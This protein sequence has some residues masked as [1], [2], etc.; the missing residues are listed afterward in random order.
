MKIKTK[1]LARNRW[2]GIL[3]ELGIDA[4]HLVNQ[5]GPC[6]LCGGSDRFRFDDKGGNGTYFCSGCGSGDG[7]KLAMLWTGQAFAACAAR[8]DEMC[9]HIEAQAPQT[10]DKDR[11]QRAVRRL[12]KVGAQLKPIGDLDP[13]AH[14]LRR[15][16]IKNPPREFLRYHPALGYFERGDLGMEK[17]GDYPAMVAAMRRPDGSIETFHATYLT[18]DGH[19]ARVAK[20]KKLMG[21][22]HGISGCAI[23]LS[24]VQ[25]HIGIAEGIE[26]ALSVT[27]LFG[28]PCWSVS[29]A[30]GI[31]TFEPPEGVETVSIFADADANFTGQAAAT[32]CAK[33][34]AFA[35]YRVNMPCFPEVGTDYNDLLREEA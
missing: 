32:A 23:R 29:S 11:A 9:G 1:D 12:R 22:P 10:T 20:A 24:E 4:R 16:G 26:T 25:P 14:Y 18:A 5:H 33:R 30:H 7:M 28:L 21:A 35:G 2:K 8:I 19:K 31:E 27:E 17:R 34:L 3:T 13:V 15:R 6:P